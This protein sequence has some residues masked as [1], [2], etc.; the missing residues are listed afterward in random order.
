M[1]KREKMRSRGMEKEGKGEKME[2]GKNKTF[3]SQAKEPIFF[4]MLR[5]R[6]FK[7]TMSGSHVAEVLFVILVFVVDVFTLMMDVH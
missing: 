5:I 2:G 3:F 1:K 4:F 7:L 6:S